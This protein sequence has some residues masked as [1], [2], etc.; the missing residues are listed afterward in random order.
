MKVL[1]YESSS[2]ANVPGN[3]SSKE[4]KVPGHIFPGSESSRVLLE[5]SLPGIGP[6]T[7][8]LCTRCCDTENRKV[9][10]VPIRAAL[11]LEGARPAARLSWLSGLSY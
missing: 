5:L 1:V 2:G 7:E 10:K 8:K 9:E 4:Q 3:V 11:Q 6:G